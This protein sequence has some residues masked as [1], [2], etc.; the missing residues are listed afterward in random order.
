MREMNRDGSELEGSGF[1]HSVSLSCGSSLLLQ[2]V[3][4]ELYAAS[5]ASGLAGGG[6]GCAAAQGVLQDAVPSSSSSLPFCQLCLAAAHS[7]GRE[8]GW[9]CCRGFVPVKPR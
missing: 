5:E 9:G 2:A 3:S 6:W 4:P 8:V 7:A 1:T